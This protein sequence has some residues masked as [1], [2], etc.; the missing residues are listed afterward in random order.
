MVDSIRRHESASIAWPTS[1]A[2]GC[3]STWVLSVGTVSVVM[4]VFIGSSSDDVGHR[5]GARNV[6]AMPE[7]SSEGPV[8]VA[9]GLVAAVGPGPHR[10]AQVTS[11]LRV[12]GA[13]PVHGIVD[14]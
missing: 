14:P 2:G 4:V 3:G 11:Q 7:G 8:Q 1:S 10:G 12:D 5:G 9:L 6:L 13:D